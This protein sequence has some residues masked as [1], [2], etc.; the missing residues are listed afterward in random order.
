MSS[1][2][3]N[4]QDANKTSINN[5]QPSSI[6]GQTLDV[7]EQGSKVERPMTVTSSSATLCVMGDTNDNEDSNTKSPEEVTPDPKDTSPSTSQPITQRKRSSTTSHPH[8][9]HPSSR[10]RSHTLTQPSNQPSRKFSLRRSNTIDDGPA[11]PI[12]APGDVIAVLDPAS[13]GGGGPLKRI[14]T[15]RSERYEQEQ[16]ERA[17][18]EAM[19]L[20]PDGTGILK[21][22]RSFSTNS[23]RRRPTFSTPLPAHT[24]ADDEDEEEEEREGRSRYRLRKHHPTLSPAHSRNTSVAPTATPGATSDDSKEGYFP[25]ASSSGRSPSEKDLERQSRLREFEE[26]VYPDGGYG[27]VVLVSCVILAGCCMGWNMN[28]GVFQEYYST[29][30]FP[31]QKT[32]LLILPGCFNGFFMSTSAFLAGRMGDR[33]G[34]KRV[35]YASAGLFWL[36]LF[37]ASWSTKLWQLT[38]TQGV[39]AGFGQGLAMPLFMSLPSQ[40]FYKKRGLASGIA[41]GGAG[42]GGGTITLVARQLLTTV[43]YKKTLLILSF[44]ELFFMLL[45][46]NF[47]RIRPTSPEARSGKSAPWVDGDVIRTSAFWSIM[48]GTVVGTIG[49]GMPFS[50]L[51]QYVRA[52]FTIT[53]PI[54]LALPTTLLAYMV[55]VGRALVGFVADRIG[56][57]NTYI[58]VFFLSGVIQLCLWLTA[59][60]FGATLAFAIMFGL[61]APGFQG[62]L[63]QIIVQLFGPANLATNVGLI[64]LSGAPGNLINGPIGGGLYD[65]TG[66]TTFKYTIIFGGGMQILGGILACYGESS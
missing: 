25:S 41:I 35:L 15:A 28:Y 43:G 20:P 60:S 42:L 34:F 4:N 26:H 22:F 17:E 52:N 62:I 24:F 49:Y 38:L 65:T 23:S 19:G 40:W 8:H 2:T 47:L 51:A 5:E 7:E 64:L 58:L 57:L 61:I 36:G 14:E 12:P 18:R 46:I 53:D 3:P 54:L 55:C 56:P 33:Y 32:A 39:I 45:A 44:I 16:K 30:I 66:R 31:G 48:I 13:V 11:P 37:L 10:H 29:N 27:W 63:P 9:T 50:F 21:K 1:T 6:Q 59:K